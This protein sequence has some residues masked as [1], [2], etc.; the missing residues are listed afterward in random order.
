MAAG[1]GAVGAWTVWGNGGFSTYASDVRQAPYDADGYTFLIGADRFFGQ[2]FL[3][4]F[5]LGYESTDTDTFYNGG[6][7]D[8]DGLSVGVYGAFLINETFSFDI[9]TGYAALD[10]DESRLDPGTSVRVGTSATPGA[11]L[12][13]NYDAQRAYFTANLNAVRTYGQWIVG[14]RL[15]ALHAV[16]SQDAYTEIGG[17]GARSIRRRH[18]DLTQAYGSID[19]GYAAGAFEPYAVLEYRND[20]GRDDG[21]SAGGLPGGVRTQPTDDDE[22]QG[23][24]GLRYFGGNGITGSLE[25]LRT[26]GRESFDNDS[27]NL[28]VRVPF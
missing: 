15:G 27:L 2:R 25:W 9:A 19:V 13:G 28:N 16:E 23:G 10:T 11:I 5:N 7:Q 21:N 24:L 18:I 14:A 17:A 1:S 4:G 3:A 20:L 22:W 6:G 12:L 26:E 8:R